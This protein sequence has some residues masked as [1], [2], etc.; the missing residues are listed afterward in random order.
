MTGTV[1][2]QVTLNKG[3]LALPPNRLRTGRPRA[4]ELD[5]RTGSRRWP[6]LCRRA[7]NGREGYSRV[8]R[9]RRSQVTKLQWI[10]GGERAA[11]GSH[12][13]QGRR[14]LGSQSTGDHSRRDPRSLSARAQHKGFQPTAT[15]VQ[16]LKASKIFGSMH[17]VHAVVKRAL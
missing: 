15:H 16:K 3:S 9:S 6:P 10:Y 11:Y 12:Q 17:G 14:C 5:M 8:R 4:C 2:V 13:P 7:Q 1:P